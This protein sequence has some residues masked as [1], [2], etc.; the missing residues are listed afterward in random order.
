MSTKQIVTKN[1]NVSGAELFVDTVQTEGSYY[2]FAAKH[3]PYANNSDQTILDPEDSV[4]SGVLNIYNDMLFGKKIQSTDVML[5][6]PRY[7]WQSGTQYAMYDDTD[8]LLYTKQFYVS[9]NVGSQC[10]IY[11][12]L[13][14]N[15]GGNST[16][17]PTGTDINSF[18]TPEDGY[19][20][21]YMCTA[22]DSIIRK[23]STNQYIPI[24]ANTTVVANATPGA[25]DVI[26]VEDSGLGYGN[27]LVSQFGSVQD[28][29]IGGNPYLYGLGS[30]ASLVNDFYNG[31]IIKMTSGAA[32][33]EY[34]VITDYYISG[35]QR[36]IVID[37]TFNGTI[38]A[39]DT[40]EIYPFV[41]VFDTGG[42]KQT[43]CIAR[44]IVSN[45][46]GNS[47]S[48]IEVLEN[49]SGYRSATAVIIPNAVVAVTSNAS[50]RP[51]MSPPGGHGYN[52]NSELGANY[53][54][55]SVKFIE[56]ET[57]IT[58]END[59]RI[60]GIIHNPLFAN[61][62][63][64]VD[65]GVTI[66]SFAVGEQ[67]YQYTPTRLT[68]NVSVT[69]GSN[70]VTGTSTYFQQALEVGDSVL[71]TQGTTN[72]F[73]NVVSIASNTSLNLSCNSYFT[74]TACQ[75]SLLRNLV[76][77]G[78]LTSK[79]SGEIFVTNVSASFISTTPLLVGEDSFATTTVD[80]SLPSDQQIT[81]NGRSYTNFDRFTQ[82]IK[83]TGTLTSGT[84]VE[85][86]LV[87]Q[88]S[89]VTY[90]QPQANFHHLVD[91]P[92]A[93]DTMYVTNVK[94][95]FLTTASPSSDGKVV[96]AN[97]GAQFTITNKYD[98][99]LVEDSGRILYIENLN[100]ISR[101]NTQ[102]ETIKLFLEY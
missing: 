66:G 65:D 69:T 3:T 101:S 17:E 72:I 75:I 35:G 102:T 52:A 36:I 7:D 8:E 31:C 73:A 60:V 48:K 30:Q 6:A 95:I 91:E 58:D 39:T 96:G 41:Y 1:L 38:S 18:E 94:N 92:S 99:D 26:L 85:D 64:Q 98:G 80:T 14:N 54:S 78:Y 15:N 12:C 20:W 82:L 87:T 56:N 13:F 21:K 27:Y 55:V 62:N 67:I 57:A 22:N 46:S 19:I 29:K 24:Q 51:I 71:I 44:A 81:I 53:A 43:N 45:T 89:A 4:R 37:D 33:D 59:Y 42:K 83:F 76:P 61:V 100:P 16:V 23:F 32:K 2:V 84:F 10:H 25:I 34:K 5:T 49:G 97:S 70:T 88:D 47:I 77:F 93:A 63:I 90:A 79:A 74:N 86:E 28:L 40:Y 68:G 9:V 50:L 11:K